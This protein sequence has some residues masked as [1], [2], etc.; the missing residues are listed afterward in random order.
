MGRVPG[1]GAAG[2]APG[3]EDSLSTCVAGGERGPGDHRLAGRGG[4]AGRAR[5]IG[6]RN[7]GRL[8]SLLDRLPDLFE[9]DAPRNLAFAFPRFR[10]PDGATAFARAV[11]SDVGLLVLPSVLWRSS[12]APLP[13]DH[14]RLGMGRHGCG[15]ALAILDEYLHRLGP[16]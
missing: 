12:L 15:P 1:P 4:L 3:R 2:Q 9:P 11:A 10:G 8:R 7:H 16:R 13:E 5:A 6:Q 14:L